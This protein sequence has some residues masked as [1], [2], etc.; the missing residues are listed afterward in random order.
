M[1][2]ILLIVSSPRGEASYSTRVARDLVAKFQAQHPDAAVT[3]RDLSTTPPPVLDGARLHAL[4]TPAENRTAEQRDLA[5]LSDS[6]VE[7]LF[8]ADTIVIA[9]GMINFGVPAALKAWIDQISRAGL[10]FKYGE[11][12]PAG[13]VTGKKVY[14]VLATGGVYSDGPLKVMDHQAPYLH[15]TLSFLGMTDIE[16]ILVEGTAFGPDA[17]EKA[18][19]AANSRASELALA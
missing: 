2:N 15:S 5:A 12:G 17:V 4:F 16:T 14:L 6:L 11:S 13:L 9:S 19:E 8:A 18:L 3:V 7:E 1:K 10:T